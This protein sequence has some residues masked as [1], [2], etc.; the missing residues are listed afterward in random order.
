MEYSFNLP[1][2]SRKFLYLS[3]AH[4]IDSN[5][6]ET[7]LLTESLA[8]LSF[9]FSQN[10][11]ASTTELE[12][13][14]YILYSI[15]YILFSIFYFLFSIFYFLSLFHPP[16]QYILHFNIQRFFVAVHSNLVDGSMPFLMN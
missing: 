7:S 5:S 11:G 3:F 10:L 8:I 16:F 9:H 2:T 4:E 15:F 6:V 13:T 12:M 14:V 1:L